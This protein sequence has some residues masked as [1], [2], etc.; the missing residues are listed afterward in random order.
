[1]GRIGKAALLAVFLAGVACS[2]ASPSRGQ[3]PPP[4][5][6]QRVVY[7]GPEHAIYTAGPDGTDVRLL[8]GTGPGVTVGLTTSIDVQVGISLEYFWPTWSPMG[9]RLAVSQVPGTA[10]DSPAALMVLTLQE[11]ELELVRDTEPGAGLVAFNTPHYAQ[12]SPDGRHLTFIAPGAPGEGLALHR[13]TLGDSSGPQ[14]VTRGAPLYFAWRHDSSA[15]VI[16]HQEELFLYDLGDGQPNDLGRPSLLYRVPAFDPEGDRVAYVSE[17]DGPPTL[18]VQELSSGRETALTRATPGSAFLWS[19][20]GDQLAL[21]VGLG[22]ILATYDGLDLV[23]SG[24]GER[25]RLLSGPVMAFFWSPDGQR[26]AVVRPV[27]EL[28]ILEWVVVEVATGDVQRLTPFLP[29]S[30]QL[31]LLSFFD[32]YAISHSP[33]S[34]DSTHLVFAG[35]IPKGNGGPSTGRDGVYVLDALGREPPQPVAEGGLAFWVPPPA[36]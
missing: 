11:M 16:H 6:S 29:S 36:R 18:T 5:R 10:R 13:A 15:M 7:V 20:S 14:E 24:T 17:R 12:W 21:A 34:A 2:G 33:W 25:Q 32:Q 30:G 19:P 31:T 28:G 23:D 1:M 27:P 35:V 9:E 4:A 22:G 8:L 26:L 3:T